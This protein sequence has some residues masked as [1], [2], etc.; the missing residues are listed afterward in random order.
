MYAQKRYQFICKMGGVACGYTLRLSVGKARPKSVMRDA[1]L[2]GEERD[3]DL[4]RS[5]FKNTKL[6]SFGVRTTLFIHDTP[7]P[8]QPQLVGRVLVISQQSATT[9]DRCTSNW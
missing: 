2:E 4:K 7:R 5:G 1:S 8:H 9:R 6:R 3:E